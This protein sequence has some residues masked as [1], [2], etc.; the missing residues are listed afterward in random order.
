V[1]LLFPNNLIK[2]PSLEAGT[3]TVSNCPSKITVLRIM[4]GIDPTVAILE[5]MAGTGNGSFQHNLD[6]V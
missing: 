3:V 5:K 6:E 2:S 4:F 1:K